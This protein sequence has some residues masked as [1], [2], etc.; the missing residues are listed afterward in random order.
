MCGMARRLAGF[1][2]CA[3]GGAVGVYT[4]TVV[5]SGPTFSFAGASPASSVALLAA[6]WALVGGAV[7]FWVRRPTSRF[8]PILAAAGYAWFLL[9]WKNPEIESAF[10]FTIGL[11]LYAVC[12]ALVGHAV[13]AYPGGRLR[14]HLERGAVAAAYV[15]GLVVLGLFPALLFDPASQGCGQCPRNLILLSDHGRAAGDLRRAGV[16]FG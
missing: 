4:L 8:G 9:E 15:G 13:L 16:Y 2:V 1:A 12:P 14:S 5:R 7:L 11:C 6:G 10:A 3:L